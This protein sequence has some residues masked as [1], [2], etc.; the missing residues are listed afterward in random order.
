MKRLL[1]FGLPIYLLVASCFSCTSGKT[2]QESVLAD[3]LSV[4]ETITLDSVFFAYPQLKVDGNICCIADMAADKYYFSL[5]T[6]PE[7]KYIKS[8][9]RKGHAQNELGNLLDF[10]YRG[11]R[12][13]ALCGM[14]KKILVYDLDEDIDN[15]KVVRYAPTLTL[16][17]ICHGMTGGFYAFNTLGQYRVVEIS[18]DGKVVNQHIEISEDEDNESESSHWIGDIQTSPDEQY[19]VVPTLY[20][21]IIDYINI[22]ENT[23]YRV[24]SGFGAPEYRTRTHGGVMYKR[25]RYTGFTSMYLSEEYCYLF[26]VGEDANKENCDGEKCIRKYDYKGNEV[27]R[28]YLGDMTLSSFFVDENTKTVYCTSPDADNLIYKFQIESK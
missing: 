21:E 8:F 16:A 24:S 6:F 27:C 18:S 7:F 1:Q 25:E 14:E 5:Y 28:Y 11:N 9:G 20:G 10:D 19:V 2:H 12:V 3:T 15:P 26:F 13:I 4:A 17:E 23:H 22:H